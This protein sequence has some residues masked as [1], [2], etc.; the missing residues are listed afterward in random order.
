M[1]SHAAM[2]KNREKN[3]EGS[4]VAGRVRWLPPSPRRRTS[5]TYDVH[6]TTREY[7]RY[8]L[9]VQRVPDGFDS[10]LAHTV[11]ESAAR[12]YKEA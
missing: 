11:A 6:R 3:R 7:R 12:S 2:P 4:E 5:Q 9:R 1:Q 8:Y 10:Q